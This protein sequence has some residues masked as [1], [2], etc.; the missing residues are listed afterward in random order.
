MDGSSVS[1][2]VHMVMCGGSGSSAALHRCRG[3]ASSPAT[4]HRFFVV[5]FQG[6]NGYASATL[7]GCGAYFSG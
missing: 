6:Y 2:H 5:G 4:H 7:L 3:F 1:M